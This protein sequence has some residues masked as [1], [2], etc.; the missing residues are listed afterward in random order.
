MTNSISQLGETYNTLFPTDWIELN[1]WSTEKEKD[2]FITCKS[3]INQF[4]EISFIK[5]S[6]SLLSGEY[7]VRKCQQDIE[8][9]TQPKD[10]QPV[11]GESI[12]K[13]EIYKIYRN[14]DDEFA[15][16]LIQYRAFI[17]SIN[18]KTDGKAHKYIVNAYTL[19]TNRSFSIE[20]Y[21]YLKKYILFLC[22]IDHSLSYDENIITDLIFA[23]YELSEN[24]I[25]Q[26]TG[27]IATL[28]KAAFNKCSFLLRKLIYFKGKSEYVLNFK[29]YTIEDNNIDI[30]ELQLLN[31][32]FLF[33]HGDDE[34]N[35]SSDS[36]FT[37][38]DACNKKKA[39]F[40]QMILLMNKYKNYGNE[41][42]INNLIKDFNRYYKSFSPKGEF[43]RY[44]IDTIKNYLYNCRLSY[45]LEHRNYTYHQLLA[46]YNY[47]IS[48]Q[49]LTGIQNF[50]PHYKVIEIFFK[51]IRQ[52][53]KKDSL[54]KETITE[55]LSKLEQLIG[56]FE[57]KLTWSEENSFYPFQ[58]PYS[59]CINKIDNVIV[60]MPSSFNKPIDYSKFYE[61]LRQYKAEL[62][63]LKRDV[64][65]FNEKRD[66]E[67]LK[68]DISSLKRNNIEI[69][70]AFTA[71]ITFLF[72]CV[73]I[74]SENKNENIKVLI[75][76]ISGLG[77][78]I[79][80]FCCVIFILSIPKDE[81]FCSFF[82][83]PRNVLFTIMII[84]YLI[85]LY[86]IFL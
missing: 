63:L 83:K 53:M 17:S 38:Q 43:D 12:L 44:A 51:L 27:E 1:D 74:F 58:L 77:L 16:I 25:R 54:N 82:K 29:T 28:F 19:G 78:L 48:I 24:I 73:N 11:E 37:W 69:I 6:K 49:Q 84:G 52:E 66:I 80:L 13:K 4:I 41:E 32:K 36:I 7:L 61:R 79:L 22:K 46:E 76:N 18:I 42:Q 23:R 55:E 64:D 9:L 75:T 10:Y 26:Y 72:G 30:G 40:H 35:I 3:R 8:A 86:H 71:A 47:I 39:K 45:L 56:Q 57:E 85:L 81:K 20:L 65:F 31:E 62:Q 34:K 50:F 67:N 15:N 5:I 68:L 14:L 21:K 59:E 33:L 2:S 60:F 70:G